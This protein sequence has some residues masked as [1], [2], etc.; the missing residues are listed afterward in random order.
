MKNLLVISILF[1]CCLVFTPSFAQKPHKAQK[2][3]FPKELK[4]HKLYLGMAKEA[5]LAKFP[6]AEQQKTFSD[7]REV[8][9]LGKLSKRIQSATCYVTTQDD[10]PF[11]EMIL[12]IE[13]GY[14]NEAMGAEL[15]GPPNHE[16][17]EWL[18]SPEATGLS[19]TIKVWTFQNKLVIAGALP[20]SEWEGEF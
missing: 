20:G 13:E 11:Y 17:K 14:S 8:Y 6:G 18:L 3:F 9:A 12:V 4:K 19:F 10:Q 15:F 5:L 1:L 2:K 7:F 16:G